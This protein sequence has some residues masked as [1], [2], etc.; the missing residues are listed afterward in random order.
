MRAVCPISLKLLW[1]L[2]NPASSIDGIGLA[3]GILEHLLSLKEAPKVIAATHFH[4]IF[5]N[6]FLLP[7][8]RLQLG[9]M[10][11]RISEDSQQTEDQ[12][13]YLYKYG[14]RSC[15]MCTVNQT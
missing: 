8:P 3:C 1:S 12:I 11:V 13:T 2:P 5:E 10:E 6:D 7:R 14:P 9:H 15:P 4:E